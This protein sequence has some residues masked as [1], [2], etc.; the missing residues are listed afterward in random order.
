V[1]ALR[2]FSLVCSFALACGAHA[3]TSETIENSPPPPAAT[4][5][6]S[7]MGAAS[8]I[9]ADQGNLRQEASKTWK[10]T[11]DQVNAALDSQAAQ[12]ASCMTAKADFKRRVENGTPE[13]YLRDA[14]GHIKECDDAASRYRTMI[15]GIEADVAKM[16]IEVKFVEENVLQL[17]GQQDEQLRRKNT[18]QQMLNV[19]A[20][21][22]LSCIC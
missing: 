9:R 10:E 19:G 18:L 20:S 8:S 3:E 2:S 15:K 7:T 14:K 13:V 6:P 12:A 11:S 4:A 5:A 22:C 21:H 1:S 17:R 16:L